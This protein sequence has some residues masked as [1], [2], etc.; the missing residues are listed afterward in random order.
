MAAPGRSIR[1]YELALGNGRSASPFVWRIRYALAHKGLP[2]ESEY[3][4]FREIPGKFAGRF[5][6]VPVIECGDTMMAESWDIAEYLDQAYPD[7]P[8]LFSSPA[9]LAMVRLTDQWFTA[10]VARKMLRIYLLDVHDAADPQDRPYFR[11]SREKGFLRGRSLEDFAADRLSRL[12]ALRESLAPLRAHLAKF[13]FIGGTQPNYA[14]YIVL[15]NFVWVG[16][17]ATVP[18]LQADDALRPYIERGLDLYG[19]LARDPRMKPLYESG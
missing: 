3:L 1:L 15:S 16:S 8:A 5:K 11:E 17:V 2:F 13:P 7:H 9:E 18:P 14:D 19:G 4:G 12:P 10:E 6:T